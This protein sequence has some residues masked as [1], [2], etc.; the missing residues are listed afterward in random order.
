M[1]RLVAAAGFVVLALA[2]CG[3]ER[4]ARPAPPTP[5][6]PAPAPPAPAPPAPAADAM[7]Y[8]DATT[9]PLEYEGLTLLSTL[10]DL[11]ALAAARGWRQNAQPAPLADQIVTVF[12]T[13]DH[14]VKRYKLGYEDSRLVSIEIDYRAPEPARTAWKDRFVHRR[15]LEGAWYLTDDGHNV[16]ASVADDGKQLRALHLGALR[17]RREAEAMLQSAFGQI[18]RSDER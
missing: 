13:P 15:H 12:T 2:G 16:L 8:I 9:V 6:A 1:G 11:R 7:I 3:D 10:D 4:G 5:P 14:P 17:D 18:P